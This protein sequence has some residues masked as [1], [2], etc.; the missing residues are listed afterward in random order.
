MK[1][2]KLKIKNK[3][4]SQTKTKLK[5]EYENKI[6]KISHG[7]PKLPLKNIKIKNLNK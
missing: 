6:K 1:K 7:G 4:K 3:T 2:W 5:K